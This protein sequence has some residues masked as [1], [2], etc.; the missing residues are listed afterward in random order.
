MRFDY[1]SRNDVLYNTRGAIDLIKKVWIKFRNIYVFNSSY[2]TI[3][4][5]SQIINYIV[6]FNAPCKRVTSTLQKRKHH[7][8]VEAHPPNNSFFCRLTLWTTDFFLS[9]RGQHKVEIKMKLNLRNDMVYNTQGAIDL[10]KKVWIKLRNIYVFNS[11]YR[12]ITVK[13]LEII[14]T[15]TKMFIIFCLIYC[16]NIYLNI[17]L[18]LLLS[19]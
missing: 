12:T 4:V 5:N 9:A 8:A 1:N 11:S 10:I 18:L 19:A 15:Q 2:R 3:T 17:L 6:T 13:W 16:R 7:K 14:V